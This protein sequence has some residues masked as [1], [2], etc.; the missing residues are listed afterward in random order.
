M[1][2]VAAMTLTGCGDDN[3]NGAAS[4]KVQ[5]MGKTLQR[6]GVIMGEWKHERGLFYYNDNGLLDRTSVPTAE[7]GSLFTNYTW[8]GNKMLTNAQDTNSDN[9]TNDYIVTCTFGG[10][11]LQTQES[12]YATCNFVYSSDGSL[13]SA[14][15]KGTRDEERE[16]RITYA[17]GRIAA[18]DVRVGDG[19]RQRKTKYT[20]T[21]AGQTC[22]GMCF[23]VFTKIIQKHFC[24][25]GSLLIVHPELIGLRRNEL[26][27]TMSSIEIPYSFTAP[28]N[29]TV[30]MESYKWETDRQGFVTGLSIK[31]K[32]TNLDITPSDAADNQASVLKRAAA[33]A[34]IHDDGD[35]DTTYY[36]EWN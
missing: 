13:T 9:I 27:S 5:N 19:D 16:A 2:M 3:K 35:W 14:H 28:F 10:N 33:R 31:S 29:A 36:F 8:D 15:M 30:T 22:N 26:P 17:D 1:A 18:I 34:D 23:D 24:T 32:T 21:Y 12:P 11:R 4:P 7:G 6:Y 20:F 25:P